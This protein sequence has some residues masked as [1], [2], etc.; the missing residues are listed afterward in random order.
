MWGGPADGDVW[1]YPG[2]EPP[3]SWRIA[4]GPDPVLATEPLALY[5]TEPLSYGCYEPDR[6][7]VFHCPSRDD[8]G[9]YRY[10][11]MGTT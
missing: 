4:M 3:Y 2:E 5:P 9:A 7:P 1:E 8:E 6:D 10:V 11:W